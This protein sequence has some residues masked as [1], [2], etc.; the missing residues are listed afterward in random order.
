MLSEV[1]REREA[2]VKYK[3][4]RQDMVKCQD[5]KYFKRQQEVWH[6]TLDHLWL[7]YCCVF[8]I[9]CIGS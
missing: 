9:V 4:K 5:D 7:F 2:Q 1:L 3:K 8:L 6:L